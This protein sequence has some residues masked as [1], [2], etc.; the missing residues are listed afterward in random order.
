MAKKKTK[1]NLEIE[2]VI[3]DEKGKQSNHQKHKKTSSY[4]T[5]AILSLTFLIAL[6]YFGYTLI[7]LENV[8][9]ATSQIITSSFLLVSATVFLIVALIRAK[10]NF[11][12]SFVIIASLFL[13][14]FSSFQLA[15][16][17]GFVVLP[18]DIVL[19]D[20]TNQSLV[21]VLSWA[22]ENEITIEETYENS[23]LVPSYHIIQ[24]NISPGTSLK[25]VET[26]QV[27]V[28]DGPDLKKQVMFPN[29]V[30]KNVDTVIAFVEENHF[31]NVT[32]DF[33]TSEVARDSILEQDKSGLLPRD[34]AIRM[35]ASL[36]N[37]TLSP[38][39]MEDLTNQTL[40]IASTWCKRNGLGV[41]II[42][43]YSDAIAKGLVIT[44]SVASGEMV[45]PGTDTI[46]I[47]VSKGQKITVPDFATM[48]VEEMTA[49]AMEYN[50]KINFENRYDANIAI[51]ELISSSIDA[52][53]TIDEGSEIEIVISKGPLKMEEFETAEEYRAWAEKNGVAYKEE[54]AYSNDVATG[55][56]ISVTPSVG[57]ILQNGETIVLTISQGKQVTVP[58]L[59]G[60]RRS[61]ITQI[62][63][64]QGLR[65]SFI[66]GGYSETVGRDIAI[67]QSRSSGST[68]SQNTTITI[69]LS[70]GIIEKVN[71]PNFVGQTQSSVQSQ[72][73]RLGIT[74]NFQTESNYSSTPQGQVTSQSHSGTMN[75]GSTITIYISRGPA[76]SY[77][78]VIQAT[79]F[80]TTYNE[81][82]AT[83]K[84][85]LESK[86]PGVTFV[87][88]AKDVNE[89]SGMIASDS[90]VKVGSNTFV[91]GQTYTII[92]NR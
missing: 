29:M 14:C 70:Q 38:L 5:Y 24:Q 28:S 23:D 9:N 74:C 1:P 81:T 62:C 56:I 15:S 19:P 83:L 22:S 36:G 53:T 21:D 17:A 85:K 79:W 64:D 3:A 47:T 58:Y 41:E 34:D 35:V 31:S 87:F 40:F 72:C 75:K 18:T 39:P 84:E 89:G 27:I 43:D 2:K 16:S 10:K 90:P 91:Q 6:L 42:Y 60:K 57:T 82:V 80:G 49:W 78:V 77:Q 69:T 55:G 92:V 73:D 61:E 7:D 51:G 20:F 52:G 66:Y 63:N 25:K 26:V 86:C 44:Q 33:I 30:G 54:V 13:L 32:I 12:P 37:E 45:T 65:C 4:V 46:I 67:R 71:V 48:S 76:Q 8:Q 11:D 68:I 88:Q 50:I 59:V